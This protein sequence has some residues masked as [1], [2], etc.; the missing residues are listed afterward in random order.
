MTKDNFRKLCFK[1]LQYN[2]KHGKIKKDKT[3]CLKILKIID[4]HKPKNILLYIPLENEV[5]IRFLINILRKRRNIEVYVP[6]MKDKSFVPVK[7]RL[8]LKKKRFGI[9]EP[10][11]S[12]YKNNKIPLDMV[13]VPIVGIDN[14]FRRVGFG[15]GMYD[16]FFD[17]LSKRP[18][19]V[20]TQLSMCY[21]SDVVTDKYDIRP[22]YIIT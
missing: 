18:K 16:R 5:D 13:I 14:T 11:F 20:F 1:K 22:D 19:T 8:P 6:F 7:Y 21:T 17:T 3:I 4:L 9:K 12:T 15:A 2:S 10:V